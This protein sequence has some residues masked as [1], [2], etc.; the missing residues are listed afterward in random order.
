[1]TTLAKQP[2]AIACIFIWIGLVCG[3]S[4]LE[5][6]LKFKAPGVTV[7]IGLGIGRLVFNALNKVEWV[8]AVILLINSF[9]QKDL[10]LLSPRNLYLLA[11][12]AILLLQSAW[13]LPTLDVRAEKLINNQYIAPSNL[14]LVFIVAELA[15]VGLLFATGISLL[16]EL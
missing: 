11:V 16:R 14:H 8:F 15:K 4:F 13:L 5:A 7:P 12:V 1:M 3:I 6:W 10:L 2:V 9:L